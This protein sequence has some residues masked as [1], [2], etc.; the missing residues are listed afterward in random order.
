MT[1]PDLPRVKPCPASGDGVN[2]WLLH[3]A[4]HLFHEGISIHDARIWVLERMLR[5]PKGDEVNRALNEAYSGSNSIGRITVK[6]RDKGVSQAINPRKQEINAGLIEQAVRDGPNLEQFKAI[7]PPRS[8]SD[9]P[10]CDSADLA[11]VCP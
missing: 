5:E 1:L 10:K 3:A 8:L 6:Q 11:K 2:V 9:F 4:N 7:R